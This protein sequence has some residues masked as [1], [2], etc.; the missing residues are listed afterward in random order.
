MKILIVEDNEADRFLL[1]EAFAAITNKVKIDM[2]EDG[3]AAINY[4]KKEGEYSNAS[5]P[6]LI[7]LDLNLPKKDGFEVLEEIKRSDTLK[8]IPV[9]ILSSSKSAADIC[10][11]YRMNA[12]CYLTKPSKYAELLEMVRSLHDF[13]LTRVTYC[14]SDRQ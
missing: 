3:A 13:W 11:S 7:I 14:S 6:D 8:A 5:R 4:L 2:V 9:A 1:Q 12:S 10:N